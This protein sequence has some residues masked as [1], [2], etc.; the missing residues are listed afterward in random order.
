MA[1]ALPLDQLSKNYGRATRPATTRTCRVENWTR[2]AVAGKPLLT[3]RS[4][5]LALLAGRRRV[6]ALLARRSRVLALLAGRSRVLALLTGRSRI[7]AL[8]D[9][10]SG[11]EQQAGCDCGTHQF[12]HASFPLLSEKSSEPR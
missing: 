8:G 7:L 10:R 3:G 2:V 6:L 5:I 9:C 4:R 12:R 11:S 1:R